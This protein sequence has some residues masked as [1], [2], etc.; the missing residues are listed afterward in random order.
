MEDRRYNIL[1]YLKEQEDWIQI[2]KF[3]NSI[4]SEYLSYT[5]E[6]GSW[7]HE[8]M[9]NLRTQ[10]QW[11]D[12]NRKCSQQYR[13]SENGKAA[14]EAERLIREES[15]QLKKLEKEVK[16][17]QLQELKYKKSIRQLEKDL[18][19]AQYQLVNQQRKDLKYKI[20]LT[21]VGIIVGAVVNYFFKR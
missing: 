19:D 5:V 11:L 9:I 13:L 4:T 8:I 2:D 16:E 21:I 18:K 6:P 17:H 1:K 10:K 20:L 15:N 12:K 7:L 3:P 14:Y